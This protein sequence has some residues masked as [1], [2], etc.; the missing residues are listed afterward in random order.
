VHVADCDGEHHG[1]LPPGH[2][3]T[4]FPGYLVALRDAGYVGSASV[5][6]EFPRD[7]QPVAE[8]VADAREATWRLLV[9]A[10]LRA[11]QPA[12]TAS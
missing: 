4:P 8:W 11:D 10:G 7:G 1:D 9:E 3:T 5:E 2:G 6:L 12:S